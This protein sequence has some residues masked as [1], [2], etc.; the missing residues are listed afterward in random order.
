[1]ASHFTQNKRQRSQVPFFLTSTLPL[2]Q[3]QAHW[4]FAFLRAPSV[5][6]V[7]S[8][9]VVLLS[10][11]QCYPSQD[12]WQSEDFDRHASGKWGATGKWVEAKDAGKH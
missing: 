12:I 9:N 1:V 4:V 11:E 3:V 6:N 8:S 10:Q 7:P 5:W 2:T